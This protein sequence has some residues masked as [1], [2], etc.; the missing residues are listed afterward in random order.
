[1]INI[2]RGGHIEN[3]DVLYEALQDGTL[4][5]VG[6]DVFD[7]EP[8]DT[9]HPIFQ[10][11]NCITAPHALGLSPRAMENIFKSMATDMAK[12]SPAKNRNISSIRKYWNRWADIPYQ[13]VKT[14]DS[15]DDEEL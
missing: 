11:A 6:L 2:A 13:M 12:V 1:M 8:P 4:A 7:P 14:A 5:G 3:L 15:S 9:S 10:L